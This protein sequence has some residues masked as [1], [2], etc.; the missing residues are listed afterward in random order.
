MAT[1]PNDNPQLSSFPPPVRQLMEVIERSSPLGTSAVIGMYGRA[2]EMLAVESTAKSGGELAEQALVLIS[3]FLKTR[4]R[5]T[6][7]VANSFAALRTQLDEM[8]A[9]AC[10]VEEVSL[11]LRDFHRGLASDRQERL[12][13]ITAA[14]AN[15][16]SGA[17][18]LLLYDYSSTVFKVVA[19][20]AKEN[21]NLQ[22]VVPE[23]R[24]CDGGLPI[25][26]HGKE[27]ACRQWL[28]PD[29]AL[30]FAMPR[31]DAVLVGVETFFRD[32]SFTNTVGSLTTAIVA[33]HFSVPFLAVTDLSKADHAGN[34]DAQPERTFREPLAGHSELLDGDRIGTTYPPLEKTPGDLVTAYIT[35]RGILRPELVWLTASTEAEVEGE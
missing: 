32:G 20:L 27:L 21:G 25:L 35:E 3:Y 15:E 22:L 6:V 30:A 8:R 1:Q 2:L 7:A 23:S 9:G 12:D 10:N 33:N 28:V 29:A 18:S 19:G 34:R 16:L 17:D 4:G 5:F 14:G 11:A 13:A 24:T 26:R 31:C